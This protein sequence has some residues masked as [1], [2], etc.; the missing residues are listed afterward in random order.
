MCTPGESGEI[1]ILSDDEEDMDS[2]TEASC[3][4]VEAEDVKKADGVSPPGGLEEDL[5]VTFSR[6][7]D[8][9][10][11]ARYDCPI[12][13]FTAADC[14]TEAPVDNNHRI[15]DQC[16]CY[17]CD[18][19]A[20]SCVMWC[21]RGI[22]HCNSHK[23]SDFW[24]NLRNCALLG[25]L[26]PFNLTLS[27][28]D[29]HLREAETRLQ[30]FRQELSGHLSSFVM[31]QMLP[32]EQVR[33]Y[34]YTPVFKFVSSFLDEAD[35]RDSRAAAIMNL[36]A[37]EEFIRNFQVSS[38]TLSSPWANANLARMAL[39]QRV[40]ASVQKL[41]VKADFT[42]DFIHKLQ[43]F[44]QKRLYFTA[45]MKGLRNSLCVRPWDDVLLV[46][47]LKGQNVSGF[48]KD[49]G[50]KD[51]LAEQIS[52][53]LLRSELLQRQHR[54]RE[55]CRYLR[56]VQAIPNSRT[57]QQLQDLIP[58]FTCMEGDFTTAVKSLFSSY[59]APA[60]RFT[61]QV[62]L[63]YLRLFKTA[64]APKVTV[65]QPEQLCLSDAAWDPI[66]V[67][68]P[69]KPAE[70]VKFAL[71]AQVCSSAVYSDS[72]CW[73]S[74]L[75]IAN[76]PCG[77]VTAL[78]VPRPEFLHEARNVV[79]L[80]LPTQQDSS[81]QIPRSFQEEYP[82]QALLLLVAGA[83]SFRISFA[84]L[85]PALPVINTFKE[86]LWAFQWLCDGLS[87]INKD[88]LKSFFQEVTQEVANTSV[89]WMLSSAPLVKSTLTHST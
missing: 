50:K 2:E 73:C 47:V 41:M 66:T 68:V 38:P 74:L 55:L 42:P 11:H 60:S 61:P 76:S 21:H 86:N 64:T 80:I 62:F 70:L 20:S 85:T 48:R 45:E 39:L 71:R 35:K 72:Q 84:P 28:I 29:S 15:C 54:Y 3:L 25:D 8:V 31:G 34:N 37:A 65:S 75:I 53:V 18:K 5:V 69:L 16:F 78:P 33:V 17:I 88:R 40:I 13:A 63:F 4:I 26:K 77:S 56:V 1:I 36:G 51:V 82:D 58:F 81:I 30:C 27:E 43:D 59:N 83:L 49:K 24:K 89:H 57:F 32:K 7:A 19:L 67:A 12:H 22:C 6:R 52:V 14:E 10:P 44:Y 23:K 46:S 79:K 9:L 87:S